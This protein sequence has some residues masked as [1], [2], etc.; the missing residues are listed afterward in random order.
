MPGRALLYRL[1]GH[2]RPRSDTTS[3]LTGADCLWIS[4][5]KHQPQVI[6]QRE[7]RRKGPAAA[8]PLPPL[9]PIYQNDPKGGYAYISGLGHLASIGEADLV[10]V[11]PSMASEMEEELTTWGRPEAL[12]G[13]C[14]SAVSLGGKDP[15]DR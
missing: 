1:L 10:M 8:C 15:G 2:N 3:G 4:C 14:P 7:E 5:V 9:V 6:H 13:V 11:Q 12:R